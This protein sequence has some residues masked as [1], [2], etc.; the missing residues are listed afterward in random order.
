MWDTKDCENIANISERVK[1][2]VYSR[3]G[4][5]ILGHCEL[6]FDMWVTSRMDTN[7]TLR[8]TVLTKQSL[9]RCND[10]QWAD[11]VS[12]LERNG[13]CGEQPLLSNI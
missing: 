4:L 5:P 8:L 6:R 7:S 10:R 3:E 12:M 13:L 2:D 1:S 11:R 9:G